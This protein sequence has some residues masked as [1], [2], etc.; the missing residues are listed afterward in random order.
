VWKVSATCFVFVGPVDTNFAGPV[1]SVACVGGT[2][3]GVVDAVV[4]LPVPPR[5]EV[6][7]ADE[8]PPPHAVITT[9]AAANPAPARNE[10]RS[11]RAGGGRCPSSIARS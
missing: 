5:V 3:T 8:S 7:D 9:A 11:K 6:D 10:R 1:T 4:V 2:V